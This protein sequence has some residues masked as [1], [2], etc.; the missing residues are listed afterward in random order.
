M[1]MVSKRRRVRWDRIVLLCIA[2]LEFIA[3]IG[4]SFAIKKNSSQQLAEVKQMVIQTEELSSKP[5]D[6]LVYRLNSGRYVYYLVVDGDDPN[7]I[8]SDKA[9][10]AL[11][12]YIEHQTS[13]GYVLI[14]LVIGTIVLDVVIYHKIL[15]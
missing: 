6:I 13:M 15:N 10:E 9:K 5:K 14:F 3:I 2:V 12:G 4:L 11:D 7:T 1:M 8:K